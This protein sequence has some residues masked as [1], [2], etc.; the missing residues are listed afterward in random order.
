MRRGGIRFPARERWCQRSGYS[1]VGYAGAR[2]LEG[3]RKRDAGVVCGM[4]HR[5]GASLQR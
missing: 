3:A 4:A 1:V 2:D 5:C